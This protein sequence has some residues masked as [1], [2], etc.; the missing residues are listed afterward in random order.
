MAVHTTKRRAQYCIAALLNR[1]YSTSTDKLGQIPLC[2]SFLRRILSAGPR[3]Y[4]CDVPSVQNSLAKFVLQS[5]LV[6]GVVTIFFLRKH[7]YPGRRHSI[8]LC[9]LTHASCLLAPSVQ[10]SLRKPILQSCVLSPSSTRMVS[11]G[12][13][14]SSSRITNLLRTPL[15]VFN[16]CLST[17]PPAS[18]PP[19]LAIRTAMLSMIFR[20][21]W[22]P[23]P[24]SPTSSA[25]SRRSRS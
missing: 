12:I 2:V 10:N 18:R 23:L 3:C 8:S 5:C 7:E 15:E 16:K 17:A 9:E 20:P 21:S 14:L 19:A 24:S 4:C 11:K 1:L 13:K 25:P 22:A 6:S